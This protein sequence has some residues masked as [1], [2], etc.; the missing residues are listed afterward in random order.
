MTASRFTKR[1]QSA[2]IPRSAVAETGFR[3]GEGVDMTKA[4]GG[5]KY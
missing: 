2:S 3:L 1:A 5:T 4:S